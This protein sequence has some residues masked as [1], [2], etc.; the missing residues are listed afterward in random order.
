MEGIDL[1]QRWRVCIVEFARWQHWRR[2]LPSPAASFLA[3]QRIY[4]LFFNNTYQKIVTMLEG[5]PKL[6][7]LTQGPRRPQSG[8]M[9][10]G[11]KMK[12]LGQWQRNSVSSNRLSSIKANDALMPPT[13]LSNVSLWRRFLPLSQQLYIGWQWRNFFIPIYACCSGSHGIGQGNVNILQHLQSNRRYGGS[14]KL[15]FNLLY[16]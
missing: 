6:S 11:N 2:S 8:D 1:N 9:R 12:L 14:T 10:H 15:F 3:N 5:G 16:K 4:F 13:T 7:C